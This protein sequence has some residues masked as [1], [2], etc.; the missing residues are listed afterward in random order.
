VRSLFDRGQ[1]GDEVTL[2]LQLRGARERRARRARERQPSMG[3]VPLRTAFGAPRGC[4]IPSS[5]CHWSKLP[6]VPLP[7]HLPARICPPCPMK[8]VRDIDNED[9]LFH[10]DPYEYNPDDSDTSHPSPPSMSP[11]THPLPDRGEPPRERSPTQMDSGKGKGVSIPTPLPSLDPF[12]SPSVSRFIIPSDTVVAGSSHH[13][14][15][16]WLDSSPQVLDCSLSRRRP[17]GSSPSSATP[18]LSDLSALPVTSLPAKGKGKDVPPTLPPL[19]FSPTELQYS[20]IDWPCAGQSPP[21]PGPSSYGSGHTSFSAASYYQSHPSPA[22]AHDSPSRKPS[23]PPSLRRSQSN[24]SMRSARSSAA[25]SMTKIR[26]KLGSSSKAPVKFARKLL[27]R[28]KP[29]D[30]QDPSLTGAENSP[31]NQST[32]E[33]PQEHENYPFPC[34]AVDGALKAPTTSALLEVDDITAILSEVPITWDPS[35]NHSVHLPILKGKGRSYSSP[36][37]KSAFDFVPQFE[38]N[39]FIPLS[40]P[41][42]LNIFDEVLPRELK[43]HIF[44]TLIKL[45]EEEHEQLKHNRKWTCLRA[46]SSKYRWV[47]RNRAMRE[48]VKFSRVSTVI[49]LPHERG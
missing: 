7:D 26:I 18:S 30:T 35:A 39:T 25:Q 14:Q 1:G 42:A 24:F 29:G 36:F 21:S 48:L 20:T 17:A 8:P 33:L 16:L 12:D 4:S 41:H 19:S 23:Q 49:S 47:G 22:Q 2:T 27:S 37:P 34:H 15:S 43:L 28:N 46:S 38:P 40:C 13:S 44:S 31:T 5:T 6:Y 11:G 32:D 10:F 45:H 9:S 3:Q